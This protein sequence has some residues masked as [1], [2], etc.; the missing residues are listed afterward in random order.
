L[1]YSGN[2]LVENRDGLIV[3]VK[4]L[5]ANDFVERDAALLMLEQIQGTGR[6]T[7]GGDKGY[8][9]ADFIKECRHMAVTPHVA[10]NTGL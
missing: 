8:D 2:L 10:Q 6:V 7:A 4:L 9:T 5:Q 3:D 1:N